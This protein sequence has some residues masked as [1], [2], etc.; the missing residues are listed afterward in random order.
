MSANF[1]E[2][3]GLD[4]DATAD[5]IRRAYRRMALQFHPDRSDA[6]DAEER[7][8]KINEAYQ[9]L[10]DESARIDYDRCIERQEQEA[11]RRQREAAEEHLRRQAE[12]ERLRREEA[13]QRRR[14]EERRQREERVRRAAEE[15]HRRQAEERLREADEQREAAEPHDGS[16]PEENAEVVTTALVVTQIS[17]SSASPASARKAWFA[18]VVIASSVAALGVLAAGILGVVYLLLPTS[19]SPEP[20]IQPT[21]DLGAT[22]TAAVAAVLP[23][24][25]ATPLPPTMVSAETPVQSTP[26][27]GA[28]ITAALA[29]ALPKPS[30]TPLAA[31]AGPGVPRPTP[32]N[33]PAA[34]DFLQV[35]AGGTHTCGLKTNGLVVCWGNDDYGQATPPEGIFQQVS[36]GRRHTC[37]VKTDG[38]LVCWG[39]NHAFS[40]EI[41]GQ[42]IAGDYVGQSTPPA[43]TFLYIDSGAWRTCGVKMD[44]GLLC[45]G[46]GEIETF[47]HLGI[48]RPR[49]KQPETPS[50]T[51]RKISTGPEIYACGIQTNGRLKCWATYV[52]NPPPSG[53]FQE[54]GVGPWHS[55]GLQTD[56]RVVCWVTSF[57]NNSAPFSYSTPPIGTF[58]QISVGRAYTCGVKADHS[59]VSWGNQGDLSYGDLI[60][61]Y[62]Q[63]TPPDGNFRQVDAGST[64]TCGVK[65]IGTIVCWGSNKHGQATPP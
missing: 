18:G 9:V 47:P 8:Q 10:S 48:S 31:S 29:A 42:T 32:T 12:S 6:P 30:T 60:P 53:T 43:G 62:G 61:D 57:T 59:A 27:L 33:S 25:S 38:S 24:P 5:D 58:Q 41:R 23:T 50:G 51:F 22:I 4:Q 16:G 11:E 55:C 19:I 36:A 7:F 37:G 3:L 35:S 39:S 1:Y 2:I 45:W 64:H 17:P 65:T 20:V 63:A 21:P 40:G 14:A 56:G 52:P 44:G 15:R 26:D 13:D 54:I 28:T 46:A 34:G 49:E